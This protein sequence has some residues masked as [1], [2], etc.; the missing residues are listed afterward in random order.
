VVSEERRPSMPDEPPPSP[1]PSEE[2]PFV[3][4]TPMVAA[5]RRPSVLTTAAVTFVV[6]ALLHAIAG[7][8]GLAVGGSSGASHVLQT[9]STGLTT[10]W[11][12]AF[13]VLGTLEL[14]AGISVS[15]LW[16]AG[17]ALGL[18]LAAGEFLNGIRVLAG[19][20]G[21]AALGVGVSLFLLYALAT[22]GDVFARAR[23]R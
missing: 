16:A 5:P 9:R 23:R 15:R 18:L 11:A 12:I 10:T 4:P 20:Q 1:R 17:R 13:I 14:A 8:L 19:G 3:I 2:V 22:T 6:L 21:I 7:A